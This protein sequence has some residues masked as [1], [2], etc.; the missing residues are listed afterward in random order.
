MTIDNTT[1]IEI[2]TKQIG[3]YFTKTRANV[4]AALQ[5]EMTTQSKAMWRF[6]T[7]QYL[8][9]GTTPN[10][11]RM[12]SGN[13]IRTTIPMKT[14]IVGSMLEG[15]I[16]FGA[17]YAPVHVGEEGQITKI[18]K[19]GAK[20]MLAIPIGAMVKKSGVSRMVGGE[21]RQQYPFLTL[22][23]SKKGNLILADVR[24]KGKIIPYFVLK[25]R[26]SVTT[27]VFPK[28]IIQLFAPEVKRGLEEAI[29]TAIK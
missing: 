15:G 24:K 6:V 14:R 2:D 11:L 23:K 12:R 16:Q 20:G 18:P 29:K 3:N 28:T 21:I 10:R 13:L 5:K 22:I 9:G 7:I 27:R 25:S 17:K 1:R 19:G 26:V 8:R 4:L